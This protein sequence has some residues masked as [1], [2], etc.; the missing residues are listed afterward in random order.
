MNAFNDELEPPIDH[1]EIDNLEV[2]EK[3]KEQLKQLKS[4][5][6]ETEVK[7]ALADIEIAA[8]K[9]LAIDSTKS[10]NSLK[11]I[12]PSGNLLH[13]SVIAARKRATLGEISHAL[14][15]VF[16]RYKAKQHLFSGCILKELNQIKHMSLLEEK[17][18]I[19]YAILVEDPELC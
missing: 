19:T 12:D 11:K 9:I 18:R 16:G 8:K 5:R 15:Q 3:Q 6:D 17:C 7:L 14:E 10:A 1:L 13:L 2:L 4:Q